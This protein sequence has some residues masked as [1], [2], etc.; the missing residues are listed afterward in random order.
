MPPD[1]ESLLNA[2][3]LFC[4]SFAAQ[5]DIS[6]VLEHFSKTEEPLA[7]EHG[8][9]QLAPFL[10]RSFKG[11]EAIKEYFGLLGEYL[12]YKGMRFTDYIAD[13]EVSKVSARGQANFTWK[14]TG[15][16]WDEVFTYVLRFDESSKVTSYEVWADSG[17]AYLASK[18]LLK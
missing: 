1:R 16:S 9:P 14:S 10:G 13:V 5:Y 12:S 11:L 7:F 2:A 3:A 8:L 18:G 4:N 15:Q 6:V 17:A